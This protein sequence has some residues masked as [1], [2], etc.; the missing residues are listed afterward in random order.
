MP[1]LL[2]TEEEWSTWLD[3]PADEALRL[4]R[5]LPDA[6]MMVVA[7]GERRDGAD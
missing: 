3:A 2:T 6:R 4:Q 5:P 1:V 7:R